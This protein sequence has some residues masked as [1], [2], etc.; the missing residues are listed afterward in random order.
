MPSP[1][2]MAATEAHYRK[3]FLIEMQAKGKLP[4]QVTEASERRVR[5]CVHACAS[6]T[7]PGERGI[8]TV[9]ASRYSLRPIEMS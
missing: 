9:G 5:A 7:S 1:Q 4:R 3:E 8:V 2:V 6:C